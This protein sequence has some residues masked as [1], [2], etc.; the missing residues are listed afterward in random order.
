MIPVDKLMTISALAFL[1]PWSLS[2]NSSGGGGGG[3]GQAG[4]VDE[5]LLLHCAFQNRFM[6]GPGCINLEGSGWSDGPAADFCREQSTIRLAGGQVYEPEIDVVVGTGHCGD[7]SPYDSLCVIDFA[8]DSSRE[9]FAYSSGMPGSVCLDFGGGKEFYARDDDE[10]VRLKDGTENPDAGSQGDDTPPETA[11]EAQPKP[12]PE[13]QPEPEQL[14]EAGTESLRSCTFMNAFM[15]SAGAGCIDFTGDSW[16]DEL[17]LA[18]CTEQTNSVVPGPQEGE[19]VPS[20]NPSLSTET[21]TAVALAG[22]KEKGIDQFES[23]CLFD[24]K[25]GRT[26]SLRANGLTDST[27][28][29]AGGHAFQQRPDTGNWDAP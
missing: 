18:F 15:T 13:Q 26:A 17:A 11:P 12:E 8:D 25:D 29:L 10:W 4:P 5:P 16:T 27:C 1:L 7:L 3:E 2:C 23:L 28:A 6:A 19:G 14:P 20:P 24:L 22:V 21:C 9:A